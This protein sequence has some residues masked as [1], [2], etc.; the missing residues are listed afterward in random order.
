MEI[1]SESDHEACFSPIFWELWCMCV[2]S[3]WF[4][5]FGGHRL[6]KEKKKS[7]LCLLQRLDF[8]VV[9]WGKK[10]AF[11]YSQRQWKSVRETLHVSHNILQSSVVLCWW[12]QGAVMTKRLPGLG[13]VWLPI[14]WPI[15]WPCQGGCCIHHWHINL[16]DLCS[17]ETPVI[18]LNCVCCMYSLWQWRQPFWS[19]FKSTEIEFMC[20]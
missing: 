17:T 5:N 2:P 19:G 16:T 8:N 9:C 4:L 7:N 10:M 14:L 3:L 20:L 6:K 1:C 11:P 15:S 13:R 18:N 12:C